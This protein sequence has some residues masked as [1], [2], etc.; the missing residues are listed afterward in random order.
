MT[1]PGEWSLLVRM[2]I[3]FLC[4]IGFMG[5]GYGVFVKEN[6]ALYIGSLKD[7]TQLHRAIALQHRQ[8][9]EE[10]IKPVT[11]VK[12]FDGA[13]GE[14]SQYSLDALHLVGLLSESTVAVALIKAPGG[15]IYGV[16]RGEY[17]GCHEGRVLRIDHDR[18]EI[19]ESVHVGKR[20]VNKL[21]ILH[22]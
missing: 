19:E 4:S 17:L 21:I 16:K 14:L 3:I 9:K 22:L 5:I 6:V 20:L 8:Q 12:P 2:G 11:L 18:I 10:H 15:R 13:R 1:G 7:E